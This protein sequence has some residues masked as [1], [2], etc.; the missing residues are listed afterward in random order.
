V[1][2]V[3]NQAHSGNYSAY[4]NQDT[5]AVKCDMNAQGTRDPQRYSADANGL[6]WGFWFYT[7]QATINAVLNCNGCGSS[8]TGMQAQWKISSTR[9]NLETGG[10]GN[11]PG[12]LTTNGLPY[13]SYHS[14]PVGNYGWWDICGGL[15]LHYAS[16]PVTAN[17]WHHVQF[18]SIY[19]DSGATV[20]P[21][22]NGVSKSVAPGYGRL[23]VWFDGAQIGDDTESY[24]GAPCSPG[25]LDVLTGGTCV[26]TSYPNEQL[27]IVMGLYDLINPS[28]SNASLQI[29]ID[30]VCAADGPVC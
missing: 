6:Y 8:S 10:P 26:G 13:D 29:W 1:A 5:I 18:W 19:N 21:V 23:I 4:I 15:N 2:I 25:A 22:V 30:D 3:S 16:T 17:A 28:P 12:S 14:N 27:S 24:Y 7:D 9:A 20:A 11:C